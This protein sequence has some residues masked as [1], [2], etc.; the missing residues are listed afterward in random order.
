[1]QGAAIVSDAAEW[2]RHLVNKEIGRGAP[3]LDDAFTRCEQR[4]GIERHT[5]WALRYHRPTDM[6]A[7]IYLKLKAA[8]DAEC[9]RQERLYRQEAK[10]NE[11]LEN[12]VSKTL[13]GA[14]DRL[15]GTKD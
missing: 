8:Y 10:R 2:A 3:T 14:A 5:F 6:L 9:N 7:S 12:A 11:A 1:M 15:A 13:A 4:Y